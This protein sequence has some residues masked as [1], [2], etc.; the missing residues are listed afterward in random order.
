[1]L[2]DRMLELR[3]ACDAGDRGAC[4]RMGIIIG[5]NRARVASWR[6]DYPDVFF[7]ER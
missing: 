6:R 1:M 7:Y 5:E 4:V 3:G 2:R